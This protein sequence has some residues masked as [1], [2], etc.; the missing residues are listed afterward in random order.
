MKYYISAIFSLFLISIASAQGFQDKEFLKYRVHYGFL[1]A[2]FA[3]LKVEE[4]NFNGKPHYHVVGEGSSSGAVRAFFKVDDHYE[5]YF[6]KNTYKPSKFIR[7]TVEGNHEKDRILTFNHS[8][9]VVT[10]NDL[11]GKRVTYH[12]ISENVQDMLSAFYY[13]RSKSNNDFKTGEY[14][15]LNVFLD[16]EEFP[17][18]LKVEGREKI[19]TKFGT[20]DAIRMKPHVQS[21]RVFKEQ[22][23]VTMWVTDDANL[24]PLKI[25][26]EL[27]V[28][29]LEM[30]L[31]AYKNNKYDLD[32]KD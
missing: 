16:G 7:K 12:R 17:F 9:K 24:I 4:T 28:G 19:K 1:N 18:K 2:G 11:K 20:I 31:H 26:A 32:F 23:S 21:G 15:T 13:L 8:T 25:K 30:D 14:Q 29:S 10:F 3:T 5:T 27:A 6:T 22:E